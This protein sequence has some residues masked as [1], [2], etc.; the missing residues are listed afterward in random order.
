[1]ARLARMLG[2]GRGFV[3]EAD[4]APQDLGAVKLETR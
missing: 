3:R 1:M 2:G 4:T